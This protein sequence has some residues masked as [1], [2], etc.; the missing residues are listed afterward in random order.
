MQQRDATILR[1][2]AERLRGARAML[3]DMDGVIYVGS[4]A[5]PGVTELLQWLDA[6][7]RGWMLITNNA[8]MTSQQFSDKLHKLGIDV[9]ADHIL[10]SSEATAIWLRRKIELDGWPD[11]PVITLGQPG[12][13][14]ALEA[15]GFT[16]TR[17]IHAARYAV[18][19]LHFELTYQDLADV[20]LA[21]G[22][23]ATFIGTNADHVYPTERGLQPGAGSILALLQKATGVTPYTV[24]KPNPPL[25]E[26]ALERLGAA[27]GETI[28]VGDR[29]DTDIAGAQALGLMGAAVLTGVGTLASFV[30][31]EQPPEVIT[32]G[33]PELLRLL[34]GS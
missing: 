9:T 24:G 31:A 5:L 14:A 18:A 23:G 33:L 22:N 3:F 21:I 6:T 8:A 16:L 4:R 7:G 25:Y 2:E 12:L 32:A 30:E 11:G 1:V 10:G 19:G 20:T 13:T 17:D 28:M 29:Y 15:S 27:P 34:A 26:L